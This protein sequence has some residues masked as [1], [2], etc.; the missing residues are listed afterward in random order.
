MRF[1]KTSARVFSVSALVAGLAAC[2]AA[3][4]TPT[5]EKWFSLNEQE[6]RYE[7]THTVIYDPAGAVINVGMSSLLS[8]HQDSLVVLKISTDGSLL[9]RASVDL[10]SYDRPWD[11]VL[12]T[13]GSIYAVTESSLVKF[14]S[15]GVKQWQRD[16]SALIGADAAIRDL[17]ISNN[18]LYVAGRDLYVFDVNG[19][20]T[21]TVAQIA[22]LWDVSIHSTGI[23]TAGTG[24]VRRYSTN[25][26]PVWTYAHPD[27]QNPPADLAIANDGTVYAATYNDEPQDSAYLTRINSNGVQ[28]W[29][30]FFNDPDTNSFQMPGM[31]KVRLLAN[32]NLVLG[33]SQ[34]PTRIINIIDP[35]TGNVKS[36]TTQK[37]GLI[38]ELDVDSKGNIYVVGGK[39]PQK[40]DSTGALLANGAISSDV[41]VTSGGLAFTSSQIFVGMGAYNNG[42]MKMY[43][44][45]YT[46]Q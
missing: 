37:V 22:P 42:E 21:N 1:N 30:K 2:T 41:D 38:D 13:D 11:A 7:T 14:N 23:Y 25:L 17:E 34:Q 31:P 12:G 24:Y 15:N 6:Q 10:G 33:L 16:I 39:T 19:N 35:A 3:Q 45:K 20:L 29:T 26:T 5:W 18:Q 32:G 8:N 28:V 4:M 9:W 43:V 36:S 40:F 27:V 46:N 44:S